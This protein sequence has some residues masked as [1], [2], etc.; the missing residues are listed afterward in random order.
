MEFLKSKQTRLKEALSTLEKGDTHA[1][2][3]KLTEL[4]SDKYA[5]AEY[6]LGDINEFKLG[7]V[8]EAAKWYLRASFIAPS[9]ASAPLFEQKTLSYPV[10]SQSSLASFS[11]CSI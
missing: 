10:E 7:M 9:T 6:W 2:I 3:S 11:C 8:P 5:E 1:A 4:A